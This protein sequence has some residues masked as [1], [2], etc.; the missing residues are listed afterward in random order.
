MSPVA[1][2]LAGVCTVHRD[3]PSTE[4]E[5]GLDSEENAATS[6]PRSEC[7]APSDLYPAGVTRWPR[8]HSCTGRPQGQGGTA[9]ETRR[10]DAEATAARIVPGPRPRASKAEK[11]PGPLGPWLLVPVPVGVLPVW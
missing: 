5:R 7:A 6:R 4:E 10:G 3:E 8:A 9:G 11:E 2:D 1:L